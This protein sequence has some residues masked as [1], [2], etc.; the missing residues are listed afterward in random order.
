[1]EPRSRVCVCSQ[2]VC[3]L[4][5][6]SLPP[7]PGRKCRSTH[8]PS[9][10]RGPASWKAID[11]CPAPGSQAAEGGGGGTVGVGVSHTVSRVLGSPHCYLTSTPP[12]SFFTPS[13]QTGT[14]LSL[15]VS[16]SASALSSGSGDINLR[17]ISP[18]RCSGFVL[19][20]DLD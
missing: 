1:M 7:A 20:G 13:L 8:N 16:V 2:K 10:S 4:S 11:S 15:S 12:D 19:R 6:S 18:R 9:P 5:N 14:C 3:T 17:K